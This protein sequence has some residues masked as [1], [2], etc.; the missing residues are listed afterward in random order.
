MLTCDNNFAKEQNSGR[1]VFNYLLYSAHG[2]VPY[3]TAVNSTL[4]PRTHN[5][6]NRVSAAVLEPRAVRVVITRGT[7]VM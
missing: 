7:V 6:V 3:L 4:I 5:Y 2:T 1:F